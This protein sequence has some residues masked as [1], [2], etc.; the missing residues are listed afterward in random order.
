MIQIKFKNDDKRTVMQKYLQLLN[1]AQP[2]PENIMTEKELQLLAEFLL[3]DPEKFHYQR[4]GRLA[5]KKVAEAALKNLNWELSTVNINNKLY[6][7][8]A[9]GYLRRDT[10]SVIYAKQFLLDAAYKIHD[11]KDNLEITFSFDYTE[12]RQAD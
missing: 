4:F 10:D 3:L 12:N 6:A 11:T 7:L 8:L 2:N 9:K 5:K 1:V